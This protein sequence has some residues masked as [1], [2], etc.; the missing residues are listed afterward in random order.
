[1]LGARTLFPRTFRAS[2]IR[3][4][5]AFPDELHDEI[6]TFASRERNEE[7]RAKVQ[8]PRF[9]GVRSRRSRKLVD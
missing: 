9:R 7:I 8:A 2:A 4:K 5:L 1:M 3:W 6:M